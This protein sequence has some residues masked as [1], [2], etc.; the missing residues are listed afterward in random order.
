MSS[1]ENYLFAPLKIYSG[2]FCSILWIFE[3]LAFSYWVITH[4]RQNAQILMNFCIWIW[5]CNHYPTQY[6]HVI[7]SV[8]SLEQ[9][10]RLPEKDFDIETLPEL[11]ASC[12]AEFRLKTAASVLWIWDLPAPTIVWA[13]SWK[14]ISLNFIYIYVYRIYTHIYPIYI[15][16]HMYI[17]SNIYAF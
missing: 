9:R 8:E 12:P 11:P 15:L 2:F 4:I 13:N 17:Y 5:L 3:T 1:H 6:Q 14:L 16:L 10:L 7:Q